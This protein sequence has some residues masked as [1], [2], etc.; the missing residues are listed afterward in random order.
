MRRPIRRTVSGARSTITFEKGEELMGKSCEMLDR[1]GITAENVRSNG[2]DPPAR[3]RIPRMVLAS[4][5]ASV[6]ILAIIAVVLAPASETG[7]F[8]GRTGGNCG[9]PCHP[10][11]TTPFLTVTGFPTEYVP[12]QDYTVTITIEDPNGLFV[13]EN[14]FDLILSTGG[15]TVVG[16]N[17]YVKNVSTVQVATNQAFNTTVSQWTVKWTAPASGT[18]T[19]DTWAVF[20]AGGVASDSPYQHTTTTVNESA[21]PEFSSLLLPAVGIGAAIV[22]VSRVSRRRA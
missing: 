1:T 11:E 14:S 5:L 10:V 7:A 16:I 20:G 4:V 15:G 21:I 9:T 12:S 13:G 22:L 2:R 19:V 17:Q 6:A 18:V 3:R 8:P